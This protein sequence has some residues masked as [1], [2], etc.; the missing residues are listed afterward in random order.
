MTTTP[1][2]ALHI[3]EARATDD[4]LIKQMIREARLDPSKLLWQNFL[5]AE[6]NGEVV[7]IG[8]VRHHEDGA[9]ELGSLVTK[10]E[11]QGQGIAGQIIEALEAR[12][13]KPMYLFCLSKMEPFYNRFGYRRVE[14]GKALPWALRRKYRLTH[15]MRLFGFRVLI[16]RKD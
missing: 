15:I 11:Y 3:R 2:L 8:Q 5:L 6:V 4:A 10:K 13:D 1:A 16:M 7:G 12:Y 9:K 14:D